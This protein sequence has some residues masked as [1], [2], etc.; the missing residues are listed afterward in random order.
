MKPEEY[1]KLNEN[2]RLKNVMAFIDAIQANGYVVS[3]FERVT[4]LADRVATG[5][6]TP[7]D[8]LNALKG[9]E[10]LINN[11]EKMSLGFRESMRGNLDA[12]AN[13]VGNRVVINNSN[14]EI[15]SAD[16]ERLEEFNQRIEGLKETLGVS[17]AL[18][19]VQVAMD[20]RAKTKAAIDELGASARLTP[21]QIADLL[22]EQSELARKAKLTPEQRMA[23]YRRLLFIYNGPNLDAIE[24]AKNIRGRSNSKAAT[25]LFDVS[26]ING[27]AGLV[28]E[29]NSLTMMMNFDDQT[30]KELIDQ[31]AAI[32]TTI[33]AYRTE[34]VNFNNNKRAY[35]NLLKELGIEKGG[36]V[37]S[38]PFAPPTPAPSPEPI[39]PAPVPEPEPVLDIP[40]FVYYNGK[41][42][43]SIPGTGGPNG[44]VA[45]RQYKIKDVKVINGVTYY[46]LDEDGLFGLYD[47]GLFDEKLIDLDNP[48]PILP[49]DPITPGA[50]EPI[51]PEPGLP[52]EPIVPNNPPPVPTPKKRGGKVLNIED[53]SKVKIRFGSWLKPLAIMALVITPGFYVKLAIAGLWALISLYKKTK[54]ANTPLKESTAAWRKKLNERKKKDNDPELDALEEPLE[55][56]EEMANAPAI[57]PEVEEEIEMG[58]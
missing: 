23:E 21:E 53:G 31:F 29:L 33:N 45:G 4:A 20:N 14:A 44:L 40:E 26:F 16:E 35:E 10:G 50:P 39:A 58:K 51:T 1:N 11:G 18:D 27:L 52:I 46:E 48:E 47:A 9:M 37:P 22:P 28:K 36:K 15:K 17:I 34:V 6:K 3:D 38:K 41:T 32:N 2:E 57:V 49:F 7:M 55:I 54:F 24:K 25:D 43:T 13:I 30:K 12:L 42:S 56:L 5:D 8:R 19:R